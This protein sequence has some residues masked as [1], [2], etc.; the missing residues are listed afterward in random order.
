[1]AKQKNYVELTG[2]VGVS[3]V[4]KVGEETVARMSL[5]T[6]YAYRDREGCAV[7]CTAWHTL[8][9]WEGEKIRNLEDISKGDKLHVCG[10]LNYQKYCG[11][12]GG[13]RTCTEIQVTSLEKL[14]R[15]EILE[16]EEA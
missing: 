8:V 7:I 3:K 10:R 12:D 13:E 14:D 6:N 16:M 15:D 5:A 11:I 2:V 4:I 9:C 1:M